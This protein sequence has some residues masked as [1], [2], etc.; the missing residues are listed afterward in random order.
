MHRGGGYSGHP[1]VDPMVHIEAV[2]TSQE[3]EKLLVMIL[4]HGLYP[5]VLSTRASLPFSSP[6][7]T[8]VHIPETGIMTPGGS[9][10]HTGGERRGSN[11]P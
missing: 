5:R 3:C 1:I 11:L 8:T 2:R 9:Q 10:K 4:Y 6:A 7:L